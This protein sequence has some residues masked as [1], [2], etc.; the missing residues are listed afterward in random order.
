MFLKVDK[1]W[2]YIQIK[3]LDEVILNL[4]CIL[5]VPRRD[6]YLH[7]IENGCVQLTLNVPSYIPDAVFPINYQQEE[8]M[9]ENG[10]I[11]LQCGS[12]HFSQQ[13]GHL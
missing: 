6:L 7:S 1:E 11:E 5:N 3:M 12:Y 9:M 4:A 8:A 10:V 2:E 13:V